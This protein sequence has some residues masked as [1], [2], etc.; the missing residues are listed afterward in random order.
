LDNNTHTYEIF[1][2]NKNAYFFIDDVLIHTFT[3]STTTL[4][5]TPSLK[6]GLQCVNSGSNDANNTLAVRSSTIN[7]LGAAETRPQWKYISGAVAATQLK[8]GPGTLHKVMVNKAGTSVQLND[9]DRTPVSGTNTLCAIDTNKTTGGV[10]NYPYDL[11]FY[12]GLVVTISG[13]GSD[14]TIIYE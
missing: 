14:T 7:R 1:W 3:G 4:V 12:N 8:I 6:I 11:D 9:D 5:D 2:T 13:A 10:G